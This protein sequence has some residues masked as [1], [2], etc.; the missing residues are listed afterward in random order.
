[1]YYYLETAHL[2]GSRSL[3]PVEAKEPA[4]QLW[5]DGLGGV[6]LSKLKARVVEA[7]LRTRAPNTARALESDWCDFVRWCGEA[8]RQSMPAS[9]E[10]VELY[11]VDLVMRRKL[12]LST[13]QRRLWA[14]RQTHIVAGV[15]LPPSEGPRAV[16]R[17]LLRASDGAYSYMHPRG[18]SPISPDDLVRMAE[19]CDCRT[20]IGARDRA[21]LVL[22]FASGLR[23]SAL[24]ALDVDDVRV[25][26]KGLL[27]TV[28]R[29][30]TDQEGK[31]RTL[32]VFPGRRRVTCPVV[33][34]DAWIRKRGIEPGPLFGISADY[35]H[36]IVQR[37]AV[38]IGLPRAD[39]G[40]HSLRAGMITAAHEHQASDL[41]IQ[42]LAGHRKMATTALYIRNPDPFSVNPLA[43]A[44]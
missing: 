31:G 23:R 9:S 25:V 39:Y 11:L 12:K 30:K 20:R 41:A 40:A 34:F 5:L 38:S 13:L 7:K 16:L 33:C 26:R 27:V 1:M 44:L 22:G 37:L 19:V 14:I 42:R 29:D 28:R 35:I 3:Q 4:E 15:Q 32:G 36:R 21:L 43:G 10:T 2:E 6:D 24:A 17:G 8:C 18:K